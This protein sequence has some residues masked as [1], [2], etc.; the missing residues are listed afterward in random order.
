MVAVAVATIVAGRTT[1]ADSVH[2]AWGTTRQVAVLTRDLPGGSAI[3]PTDVARTEWPAALVPEGALTEVPS[4][5]RLTAPVG[6]G[7]VLVQQRL[8]STAVG[9]LS[10]QLRAGEVGVQVPLGDTPPALSVG[11]RVDVVAPTGGAAMGLGADIGDASVSLR[12]AVVA[13]G[14]RVLGIDGPTLSLAVRR[15][16]AE[17]TAGASLAGLVTLVVLR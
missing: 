3:G 17:E 12:V 13:T 4:G 15:S 16:Q 14:A 1:A 9:A 2:E 11:D 5:R 7:E 10:A 8:A 6:R